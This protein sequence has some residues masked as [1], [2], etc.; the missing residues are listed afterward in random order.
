LCECVDKLIREEIEQ[1]KKIPHHI[2]G[3]VYCLI[4]GEIGSGG[5][6]SK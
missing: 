5:G 3:C 4:Q 2:L 1:D 6:G